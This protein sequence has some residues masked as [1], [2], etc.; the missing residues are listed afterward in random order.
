MEREMYL[1]IP[2]AR[3]NDPLAADSKVGDEFLFEL[4]VLEELLH[5][6]LEQILAL[7]LQDRVLEIDR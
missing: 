5:F 6:R 7:L 4:L 2:E 1:E 3:G